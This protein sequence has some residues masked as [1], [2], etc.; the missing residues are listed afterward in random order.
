MHDHISGRQV[1][2]HGI[3]LDR[4]LRIR[5]YHLTFDPAKNR[6]AFC[7]RLAADAAE[8]G[9]SLDHREILAKDARYEGLVRSANCNSC[10]DC[11]EHSGLRLAEH[12][13]L[14]KVSVLVANDYD[15]SR[16]P[17]YSSTCNRAEAD[18]IAL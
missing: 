14:N 9:R 8:T 1:R 10:V 4:A 3:L 18:I 7:A 12:R 2:L 15:D 16:S 5:A 17:Q 6:R 13:A 11:Y